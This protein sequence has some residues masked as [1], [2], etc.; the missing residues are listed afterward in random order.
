MD[1]SYFSQYNI[2]HSVLENRQLT[3]YDVKEIKTLLNSRGRDQILRALS[4][5]LELIN[6]R[7]N[8]VRLITVDIPQFLCDIVN[9]SDIVANR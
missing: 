4:K 8:S 1:P 9:P 3:S 7:E 6:V 5:I 2:N